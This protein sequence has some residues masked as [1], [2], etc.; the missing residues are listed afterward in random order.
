[1]S[2]TDQ[3]FAAE[4]R[5]KALSFL[6]SH[7]KGVFATVGKDGKPYTSLMLYVVDDNFTI[8][9]GTRKIFKKYAQL[10]EQ[11][12]IALSVIEETVDPLRAVDLTGTAIA[13]SQEECVQCLGFFKDHNPSVY[14]VESAEDYVMF[15]IMPERVRW[16]DATSG[17][18]TITE[19][20]LPK[21]QKD[22]A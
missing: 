10:R 15:R 11:P 8:Y 20:P 12:A 13:L 9:F 21:T 14:Y 16:L 19:V 5:E 4:A 7:R 18:L 1:M 17:A 6:K 2:A 3:G 22:P